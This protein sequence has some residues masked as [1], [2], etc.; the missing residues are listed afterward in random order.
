MI[1][2]KTET[3]INRIPTGDFIYRW[4]PDGKAFTYQSAL[5]DS[6]SDYYKNNHVVHI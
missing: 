3:L 4:S 2:K 5:N 1:T 6:I